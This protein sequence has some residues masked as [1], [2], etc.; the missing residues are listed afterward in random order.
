MLGQRI[1]SQSEV[2]TAIVSGYSPCLWGPSYQR[3]PVSEIVQAV[4]DSVVLVGGVPA[5]DSRRS[6]KGSGRSTKGSERSTK[7]SERPVKGQ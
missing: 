2:I 7:G 3:G 1:A 4:L 6:T 5:C